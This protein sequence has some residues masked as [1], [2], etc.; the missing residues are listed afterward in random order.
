MPKAKWSQPFRG[1]EFG[2]ATADGKS[3][4]LWPITPSPGLTAGELAVS[5]LWMK[6]PPNPPILAVTGAN[7]SFVE[8]AFL[9]FDLSDPDVRPAWAEQGKKRK[10]WNS[11]SEV[12][13]RIALRLLKVK[14]PR[15][16]I[17]GARPATNCRRQETSAFMPSQVGLRQRGRPSQPAPRVCAKVRTA[18]MGCRSPRGSV[19]TTPAVSPPGEHSAWARTPADF[20]PLNHH[21]GSLQ[22]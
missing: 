11:L 7:G 17:G 5:F 12:E 22:F 3:T 8:L 1:A 4:T 14:M 20:Y 2:R 13:R 19:T 18:R 15:Q 21:R 9:P 10:A 6:R 16:L